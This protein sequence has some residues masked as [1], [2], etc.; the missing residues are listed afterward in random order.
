M[1]D[2]LTHVLV[3][4]ALGTL[5]AWRV[6]WLDARHV[7][8][9]MVGSVLPDAAKVYLLTGSLRATIAGVEIS[10]LALQTVGVAV[11]LAVAGSLLVPPA[12]RR[13]V[14]AAL[15]G[16]VLLHVA[17]DLQVVRAGGYAPPYLYPFSWVQLPSTDL[18]LS[19]DIWPAVVAGSAAVL[20][21][22]VGRYRP[23]QSTSEETSG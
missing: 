17:L 3:A 11:T 14:L 6:G 12:E 15:V 22:T 2:L 8:M 5:A 21:W 13:A 4:Y 10:W 16:G 7:P 19:S 18:Y 23:T 1:T 9:A 20:V